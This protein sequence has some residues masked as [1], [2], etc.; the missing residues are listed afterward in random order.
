MPR[1]RWAVLL[2]I[3]GLGLGLT[4][5]KLGYN[6]FL[7]LAIT[8]LPNAVYAGVPDRGSKL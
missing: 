6:F 7:A 8:S 2:A 3:L 4:A 1:V 5:R